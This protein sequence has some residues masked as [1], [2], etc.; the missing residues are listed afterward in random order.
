MIL[1]IKNSNFDFPDIKITIIM[2]KNNLFIFLLLIPLFLSAQDSGLR[3]PLDIPLYLSGTF[4]ELRSNHF[5]SGLDIKTQG[6]EGLP[7]YAV[8]DG[9][10]YRIKISRNGY[11]KALYI[12]H[13]SGLV[14][15][16]GHLK[17]FNE[18]I[19][20]YIK[21]KQYKKQSFEIEVFPYAIELPVKK[22]EIIAYSGNTGGSSG[23]HLHF[24]IRNIKEHPLNPMS[25]GITV[26][27][28]VRPVIRNAFAYP[29]DF[30]SHINLKNQRVKLNFKPVND[31]VFIADTI[32]ANGKIGFGIE[33]FDRQND[34]YNRNGVYKIRMS[35][36]GLPV[37]EHIMQEFSFY[38]SHYINTF[39][40]Y[41]YYKKYRRR[42]QKLWVEPYNLLQIYSLLIDD[43]M[44][45]INNHNYY[46]IEIQVFDFNGNRTQLIVPV[47]GYSAKSFEPKKANP[48]A[49][50]IKAHQNNSFQIGNWQVV[51]PE[52][53][54]YYDFD[55][56]I[57]SDKNELK[58][59]DKAIPLHKS[60]QIKY[61]LNQIDK[62]LQAYAYIAKNGKKNKKYYI[63][64]LKKNDTLTGYSKYF[65]NFS[66]AYDSVKPYI[67]PLNFKPKAR[68]NN[69]RYLKFKIG[70]KHTGINKYNGYIDNEWILLEYDYKKGTLTYD[71]SDKKLQ[72]NRHQLKIIV[73]DKM[74]NTREYS[75]YF[76]RNP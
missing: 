19:Q 26:E 6:R 28:T 66:I 34:S 37:Y 50:H 13:P 36:N 70:D 55:I 51:F 63:Y 38:R 10:V 72:G 68:L 15:V 12:K 4:G 59:E 52:K 23:A 32:L 30:H 27:D 49:Y 74:G 47:T 1:K 31:S 5:H 61:P 53:A 41:S 65:G 67:K 56:E 60:L 25:Y 75:T 33:S 43:G 20:S 29:L 57:N 42:I 3:K 40:D 45:E 54:A 69:Y 24:E 2:P 22:G 9:Y 62:T 44:I 64:S 46:N 73:T 8:D 35:V 17:K 39:I 71:F 7:V 21:Q 14:S 58:I 11:G 16:Y 76:Y 18:R 48:G